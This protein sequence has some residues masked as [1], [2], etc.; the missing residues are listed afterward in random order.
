MAAGD[1]VV[2]LQSV[3]NGA[4]LDI[5]PGAGQEWVIHN[6]YY[7]GAV[8]FYRRDGTNDLKFDS[9]AQAGWFNG[10]FCH[11][12]NSNWLGIKNVSGATILIGYDGIAT[13]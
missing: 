6:V 11:V 4:F 7:G 9:D 8:E 2:G 10:I 3:V 13:K 12:T 1:A 5:R